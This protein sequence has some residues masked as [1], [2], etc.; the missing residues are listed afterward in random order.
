MSRR[1]WNPPSSLGLGI[2]GRVLS[3]FPDLGG[4][5]SVAGLRLAALIW[6]VLIGL[7]GPVASPSP[8]Y[9]RD[10][11]QLDAHHVGVPNLEA[12]ALIELV[13]RGA[14]WAAA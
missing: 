11:L 5:L 3:W 8:N 7:D 10:G 13:R 14:M 2:C 12:Q 6:S 4:L 9:R 1:G